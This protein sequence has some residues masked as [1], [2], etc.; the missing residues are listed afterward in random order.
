MLLLSAKLFEFPM[1]GN[2]CARDSSIINRSRNSEIAQL[3]GEF[4]NEQTHFQLQRCNRTRPSYARRICKRHAAIVRIVTRSS[5]SRVIPA[6]MAFGQ[7]PGNFPKLSR[8]ISTE[9]RRLTKCEK[10]AHK[11]VT[12][13]LSCCWYSPFAKLLARKSKHEF[14]FRK[15]NFY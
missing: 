9:R 5:K 4:R 1:L 11:S 7:T 12:G 15:F 14:H 2:N 3:R 8:I 13:S 6:L 10:F